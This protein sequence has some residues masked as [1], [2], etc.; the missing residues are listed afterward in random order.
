MVPRVDDHED[1]S[2]RLRALEDRNEI[3]DCL[4]RYARGM[5]RLDRELARSAYHDDAIDD[6]DEIAIHVRID[7][8][9]RR[10]LQRRAARAVDDA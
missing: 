4:A 5:D 1:L 6:N 2:R 10:A 7:D 3:L 9:R 8:R